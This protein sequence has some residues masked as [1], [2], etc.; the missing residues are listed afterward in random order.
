[1]LLAL[2]P[3]LPLR[4][5]WPNDL[6]VN[7]K[8]IGGILCEGVGNR[9]GNFLVIGL[10]LNCA[11]APEGLDQPTTSLARELSA[12]PALE[13][14]REACHREILRAVDDLSASAPV[15]AAEYAT[16]SVFAP[17]TTVEWGA[18]D[19]NQGTVVGLGAFGE[20]KV[21]RADGSEQPLY[22]EDVRKLRKK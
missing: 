20:L 16:A 13:A 14:V 12:P 1:A 22:A 21:R 8:K 2:A 3:E 11:H 17:G 18:E 7:E 19:G 4:I 5:K 6:W 9:G 10:G 15:I